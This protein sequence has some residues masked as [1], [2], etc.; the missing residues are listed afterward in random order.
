MVERVGVAVAVEGE[1]REDEVGPARLLGKVVVEGDLQRVVE[2]GKRFL[3]A[4][5][6]RH[7]RSCP[8]D[9][10]EDPRQPQRFSDLEGELDPLS[11]EVVIADSVLADAD[12]IGQIGKIL[13]WLV[14]GDDGER[15]L[16]PLEPLLDVAG[17]PLDVGEAAGDP[18]RCMCVAFLLVE[19][20]R[21]LE[22]PDR[23]IRTAAFPGRLAAANE[24]ARLRARLVGEL[25]R[26]LEVALRLLVGAQRRR[27]LARTGEVLAG[28]GPDLS[29]VLRVRRRP[30]GV[31]VVGGDD[32]DD[33]LLAK[34]LLE[35]RSGREM[36]GLSVGLR[37]RLVGDPAQQVLE[38]DVLAVLRRAR[39]GL[40]REHLL[41]DERGEERIELGLGQATQRAEALLREGLAE[42][43][44]VLE[45]AA[46]L[47]REAVETRCD[48]CVQRLGHFK[49]LD[50]SGQ[51]IRG[52]LLDEQA[53]VEQHPNRLDRVQGHALGALEDLP[54]K[55]L[56]QPRDE[57]GEQLVHRLLRERLEVDRREVAAARAPGR[58][59]LEELRPGE[60]G[61]EDRRAP[62]P[63]EQVLDEV[64]Q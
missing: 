9:L 40:D 1:V 62:R 64:Q 8:V 27:A 23:R 20:D 12:P 57:P 58:P 54:A 38:E 35:E 50:C 44:A 25:C 48:Q 19:G 60:G 7:Q 28:F 39:I 14:A 45:G 18:C 36:L 26:L 37:K 31:H 13:V 63:L 43:G 59:T 17:P 22:E 56:G 33:L 24:Q 30:V 5:A 6:N 41:A 55:L 52:P 21:A 47:R 53:A 15:P 34:R 4:T 16:H 46:F 10:R 32:L 11:R 42:D 51:A 29:R 3:G 61:D 2:E 49:R